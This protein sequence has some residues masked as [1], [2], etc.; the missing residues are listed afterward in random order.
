MHFPYTFSQSVTIHKEN[1]LGFGCFLPSLLRLNPLLKKA[2]KTRKCD[3]GSYRIF[4]ELGFSPTDPKICALSRN[5]TH[6]APKIR[7]RKNAA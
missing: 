1:A 3:F 6:I 7:Y 2:L 4:G 5:A